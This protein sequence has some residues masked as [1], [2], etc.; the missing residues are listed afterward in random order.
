VIG[1]RSAFS[2]IAL[3]QGFWASAVFRVTRWTKTH[4]R[5]AGVRAIANA[6]CVLLQ[7]LIEVMTGISIPAGC[8]IGPGLYIGH[9][10]GIF[11]DSECR[12]GRNCNLSQGVTIGQGG[13]GEQRGVPVLGDRVHVGANAVLLGNITIGDDAVIGAGAVVMSSVPPRG[14]AV[15]NPARVVGTEGSFEFVRYDQMESDPTR[16]RAL[17]DQQAAAPSTSSGGETLQCVIEIISRVGGIGSVGPEE[18]IYE[19]GF[20]SYRALELLL[21]LEEEFGASLP[22]KEFMAART[23]RAIVGLL[24]RLHERQTE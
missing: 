6:L 23:P 17:Q 1:A 20:S 4:A 8:N 3:T 22:D 10:G 15:G 9:F 16:E 11:V 24:D 13:R 14:I 2:V 12:I 21:A 5:I 19:A 18:N 7:K